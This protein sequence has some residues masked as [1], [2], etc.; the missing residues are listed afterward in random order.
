MDTQEIAALLVWIGTATGHDVGSVPLPRIVTMSPQE[1]TAEYYSGA[2]DAVPADG[3][4]PRVNA[5]YAPD[6]GPAGTIYVLAPGFVD[7]PHDERDANPAWRE[8]IVH[9]L[10][11]HVQWR[12]GAR[13]A[14]PCARAGEPEAYRVAGQWLRAVGADDPMPNRAFWGAIYGRC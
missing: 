3:V 7:D 14:W 11:H 5:L 1:I 9:E 2:S 10:V 12:T 6:D 13:S 4:D 8:M